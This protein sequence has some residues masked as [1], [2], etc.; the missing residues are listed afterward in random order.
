MTDPKKSG[1]DTKDKSSAKVEK[2]LT[3]IK[4]LPTYAEEED[5]S[6]KKD[7]K[8]KVVESVPKNPQEKQKEQPDKKTGEPEGEVKKDIPKNEVKSE[9]TAA[10][11]KESPGKDL[12]SKMYTK[13]D[14]IFGV[15]N[16]VALIVLFVLLSKLPAKAKD[17]KELRNESLKAQVPLKLELAEVE[18]A[19]EKAEDITSQFVDE[20]G[21]VE[22][23]GEVEGLKDEG[24]A[25]S[26]V[27]FASQRSI[28]DKTGN[29]GIP[30]VI[31]LM[32]TWEQID[33]DLQRIQKLPY[34]FRAVRINTRQMEEPG[35][36]EFKYGIILYVKDEFGEN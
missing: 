33:S 3:N 13:R 30:I 1:E 34:F 8:T 21:V 14:I 22:F 12:S 24:S 15:I 35:V 29:L 25:V 26:R 11:E 16:L 9:T 2:Y 31:T 4:E 20:A 32:G 18:E 28:E 27:N 10:R 5:V 17:L 36:I 6:G 7:Y 23:V 19:E